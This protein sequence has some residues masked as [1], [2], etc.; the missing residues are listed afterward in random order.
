MGLSTQSGLQARLALSHQP[1]RSTGGKSKS[2]NHSCFRNAGSVNPRGGDD[3]TV[4]LAADAVRDAVLPA[5]SWSVIGNS[6]V[7]LQLGPA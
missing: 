1:G 4:S 2:A 6:I 5:N 7:A 3:A